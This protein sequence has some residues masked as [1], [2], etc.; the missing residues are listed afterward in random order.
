MKFKYLNQSQETLDYIPCSPY[1]KSFKDVRDID[2][3]NLPN[4]IEISQIK[5][6]LQDNVDNEKYSISDKVIIIIYDMT[7]FISNYIYI[8][9]FNNLEFNKIWKIIW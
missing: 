3:V 5:E 1:D 9:I 8:L 2:F 7:I 6:F 4:G